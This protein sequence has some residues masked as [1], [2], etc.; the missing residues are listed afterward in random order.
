MELLKASKYLYIFT[1]VKRLHMDIY[2]IN[3][4]VNQL[5]S[6]GYIEHE[7]ENNYRIRITKQGSEWFIKNSYYLLTKEKPWRK[8]PEE[9]MQN[10]ISPNDVYVPLQSYL[11]KKI[12]KKKGRK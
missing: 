9:Y 10:Q 11:D 6:L 1:L 4:W 8:I 5:L 12:F 3:T 2:S 7:E